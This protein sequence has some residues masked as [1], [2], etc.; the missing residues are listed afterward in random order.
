MA[1]RD[2]R[3]CVCKKCVEEANLLVE[4]EDGPD[5]PL[6]TSFRPTPP[7]EGEECYYCGTEA[8]LVRPE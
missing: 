1:D 6:T 8:G 3:E 4:C 5:D 2:L 7:T